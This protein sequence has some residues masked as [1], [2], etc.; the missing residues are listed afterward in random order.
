MSF[1]KFPLKSNAQ[2]KFYFELPLI[3]CPCLDS[4]E[5]LVKKIFKTSK[6]E[7]ASQMKRKV[8]C[9]IRTVGVPTVCWLCVK[10][11]TDFFFF[12]LALPPQEEGKVVAFDKQFILFYFFV[13]RV[14]I[15]EIECGFATNLLI[16][17]PPGGDGHCGGW[18]RQDGS[19]KKENFAGKSLKK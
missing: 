3:V 9:V 13:G 1:A 17:A 11:K 14:D 16:P 5:K 8:V 6:R 18:V 4:C 7:G 2:T 10:K 15:W 19:K 12:Q